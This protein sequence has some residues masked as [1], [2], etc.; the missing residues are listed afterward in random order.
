MTSFTSLLNSIGGKKPEAPVTKPSLGTSSIAKPPAL[1]NGARPATSNAVAG[2]KR[3]PEEQATGPNAKV[4]RTEVKV[5][6]R[7]VTQSN[8][9]PSAPKP[10]PSTNGAAAPYRGTARPAAGALN[11]QKSVPKPVPR[12]GTATGT[13]APPVG[14]GAIK[15]K[16]G[17]AAILER[18]KAAQ[19]AAKAAGSS[20]IKHKPVEKLTKRDRMRQEEAAKQQ[21]AA[22][23]RVG[24]SGVAD[25]SRSGTPVDAK[26]GVSKKPESTYKG[27]MKK[28]EKKAVERQ[29]FTYK[30]TMRKNE[31]GAP[32]AKPAAKK[33]MAQDKYGGYASWSDL[34]EAEDEEGEDYESD[35]SSDMMDAGFDDMEKEDRMALAA[36]K[37]EDQEAL[38]EEERHRREKLERKKKLEALS[39]TAAAKKRY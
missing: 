32:Q 30:G 20:T 28:P 10:A 16:K 38:A 39:K 27:T 15:P 18:A 29:E 33:G 26:G 7:S 2:V 11:T 3:K 14:N 21:K 24:K 6:V 13:S 19:E 35:A 1:T 34:D 8:G 5:P 37:K 12:P 22:P 25:R 4:V 9:Q 17:F 23:G 36:A 31:P